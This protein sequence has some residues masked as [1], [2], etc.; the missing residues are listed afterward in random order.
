MTMRVLCKDW[1]RVADKFIDGK[2]ESGVM[3][4]VGE[5][6]ISYE[7]AKAQRERRLLVTQVVFLLNITKVGDHSCYY[8]NLVVVE[9]PEGVESIGI[10]AFFGC[11]SLTTVSFPTTLRLIRYNVFI[12]CSSL[13]NIDLLHTQLQ[14][15][16][17]G[18]FGY[19]SE[20]KSMTVPDSL[21]TLG[22]F[23]FADCLKL[24]PST[25][26]V[27]YGDEEEGDDTTSEIVALL[28]SRSESEA[29]KMQISS[30]VAQNQSIVAQNQSLLSELTSLKQSFHTE[31]TSLKQTLQT[32]IASLQP[33]QAADS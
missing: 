16:G 14:E 20:L 7:E 4:V 5:N 33:P 8:A 11:R 29:L 19:C 22:V 3:T 13:E 18:A 28:R 15:I 27:D 25:I 31:M 1:R 12:G 2:V 24:V 17:N 6:G 9:I 32:L 26:N 21:Q 10:G 23:V 30:I